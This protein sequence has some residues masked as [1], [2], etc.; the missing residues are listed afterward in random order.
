MKFDKIIGKRIILYT[1]KNFRFQG[2]VQEFDGKFVEIYD[3]LKRKP[4]MISIDEIT[5]FEVDEEEAKGVYQ[6]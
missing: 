1:K 2:V 4:K 5:E 6:S 3:E